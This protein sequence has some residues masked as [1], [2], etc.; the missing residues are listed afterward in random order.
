[1]AA[2]D[3]AAP[4]SRLLASRLDESLEPFDALF[5]LGPEQAERIT[6][7]FDQALRVIGHG[8]PDD[9]AVVPERFETYRAGVPCPRDALPRNTGI[10]FLLGDL[11]LP[12]LLFAPDFGTPGQV[13]VV[14]LPHF[15]HAIHEERK[16]L[17][18]SP[19]VVDRA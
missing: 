12:F 19:L 4:R 10:G 7:I 14:D 9:G 17:E 16:F 5:H 1:M 15:L 11:G 8:K 2:F 18:L 6:D 13:R 3:F